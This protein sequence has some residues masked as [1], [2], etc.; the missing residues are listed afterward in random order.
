MKKPL[1]KRSELGLHWPTQDPFLFCAHH[2]DHYPPGNAK[3]GPNELSGRAIGQDFTLKDGWRM[4]HG[5]TVPGFPVHPHRGFETITYALKGYV[6][7][8]DSLGT[9]GRF[10]QGDVQWMTAGQG[11]Q[12]AEMFPL[13]HTKKR[14]PLELFQIWLNLPARHKMVAPSYKMLWNE[15]LGKIV[16]PGVEITVISGNY[17]GV[18]SPAPPEYSWAANPAHDVAVWVIKIAPHTKWTLPATQVGTNRTLYYYEGSGLTLETTDIP[19]YNSIQLQPDATVALQ[20]T[21]ASA[22]L[23]LLQ[24]KP[25]NEPVAHYGPF[26]MNTQQELMQTMDNYNRTQF[27]GWPWPSNEPV[28]G[29]NPTRF[30]TYSDGRTEKPPTT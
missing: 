23:L 17:Q 25:I 29:S 21:G 9:T 12:H 10:G 11:I 24:G 7:H 15:Q 19:A 30:S 8:S 22:S 5:R 1:L 13:L 3:L 4:Y 20:T 14:N 16:E 27:G 18:S 6:D 28:N 26:V 2:K